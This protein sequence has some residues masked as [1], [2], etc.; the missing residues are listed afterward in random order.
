M[1]QLEGFRRVILDEEVI[2]PG[3]QITTRG[4]AARVGSAPLDSLR[5]SYQAV[6]MSMVPLVSRGCNLLQTSLARRKWDSVCTSWFISRSSDF[7][8]TLA[9]TN[10]RFY[11]VLG[12]PSL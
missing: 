9:F 7:D 12:P 8:M 4:S 1:V 5:G 2:E 11:V 10:N 6:T 3:T